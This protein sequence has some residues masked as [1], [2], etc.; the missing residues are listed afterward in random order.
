MS[1][2]GFA[3]HGP[4]AK[5]AAVLC[6]AEEG[7]LTFYGDEGQVNARFPGDDDG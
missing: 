2:R 1:G 3:L 6:L 4:D 7:S 5:G